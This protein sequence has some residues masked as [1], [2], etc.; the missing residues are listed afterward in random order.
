M[1][2]A[3]KQRNRDHREAQRLVILPVSGAYL[4]SIKADIFLSYSIRLWVSQM[5]PSTTAQGRTGTR[6]LRLGGNASGVSV[7]SVVDLAPAPELAF[8]TS[9]NDPYW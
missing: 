7:R 5:C 2:E 4:N 3:R 6:R 1:I 8:P 9:D